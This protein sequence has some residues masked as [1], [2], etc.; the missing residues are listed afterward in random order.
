[1]RLYKCRISVKNT[2]SYTYMGAT[3]SYSFSISGKYSN[4]TSF[5]DFTPQEVGWG[6]VSFSGNS[7]TN[8]YFKGD[9]YYM[10]SKV[11]FVFDNSNF[12]ITGGNSYDI[13]V[14]SHLV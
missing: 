14:Y 11:T 7:S 4:L 10:S 2:T 8:I 6:E 9:G 1:M 13:N 12:R 3:V 5:S